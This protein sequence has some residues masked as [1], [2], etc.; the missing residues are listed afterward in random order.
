MKS[1]PNFALAVDA[2]CSGNPGPMMSGLYANRNVSNG[3]KNHAMSL[4]GYGTIHA[5]ESLVYAGINH[6]QVRHIAEDDRHVGATYW[7][8]KNS[9]S[10]NPE[11]VSIIGNES[12]VIN[13]REKSRLNI[14]RYDNKSVN[15]RQA[16]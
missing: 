7:I 9:M 3:V 6:Y 5:K 10:E 14:S 11:S 4:V 12:S 13:L 2:A 15:L 1:Y 16:Q 8:F